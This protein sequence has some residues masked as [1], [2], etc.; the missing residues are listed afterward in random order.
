MPEAL[1][2]IDQKKAAASDWFR[3][4]RDDICAVFESIEDAGDAVSGQLDA[5]TVKPGNETAAAAVK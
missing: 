2:P 4:L 5:L 1:A 3:V